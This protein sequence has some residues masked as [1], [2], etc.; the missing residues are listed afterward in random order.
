[1]HMNEITYIQ[2]VKCGVI[3]CKETDAYRFSE[4]G[5]PVCYDCIEEDTATD[6]QEAANI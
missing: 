3:L 5:E 1:M 6:D 4:N 2:C